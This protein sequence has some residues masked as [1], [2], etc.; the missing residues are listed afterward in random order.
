MV[1]YDPLAAYTIGEVFDKNG[2]VPLTIDSAYFKSPKPINSFITVDLN[3]DKGQ[4]KEGSVIV[5]F[6]FSE[7]NGDEWSDMQDAPLF[8]I[9]N[10]LDAKSKDPLQKQ[11]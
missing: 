9:Y 1:L 8:T 3:K 10:Q 6:A 4:F 7:L 11:I 5:K 2:N